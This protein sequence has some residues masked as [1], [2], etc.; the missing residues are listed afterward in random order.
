MDKVGLLSGSPRD[1]VAQQKRHIE[2]DQVRASQSTEIN[3]TIFDVGHF[4]LDQECRFAAAGSNTV[5]G[6]RLVRGV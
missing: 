6:K 1:R 5:R 3:N 2:A 4:Q